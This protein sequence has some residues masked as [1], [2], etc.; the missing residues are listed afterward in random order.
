MTWIA[1]FP[2]VGSLHHAL[3]LKASDIWVL[4]HLVVM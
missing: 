4:L 3:H 2:Q 1:K